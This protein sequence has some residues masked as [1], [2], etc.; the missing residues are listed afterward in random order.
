MTTKI[1]IKPLMMNVLVSVCKHLN[2]TT[3]E[4]DGQQVYNKSQWS[5]EL[6]KK[7]T[8]MSQEIILV[9]LKNNNYDYDST[10]CRRYIKDCFSR[11]K[12]FNMNVK[13]EDRKNVEKKM[14]ITSDLS[15]YFK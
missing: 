15:K 14:T 3:H 11:E 12:I 1:N 6:M 10:S 7:V 9:E 5:D 8:D 13:Y 4:V 2:I